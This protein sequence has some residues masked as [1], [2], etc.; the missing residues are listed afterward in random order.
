MQ[1]LLLVL[2]PLI[3]NYSDCKSRNRTILVRVEMG[4]K[5]ICGTYMYCFLCRSIGISVG[6]DMTLLSA[7]YLMSLLADSYQIC[8]DVSVVTVMGQ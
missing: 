2:N 1:G 8:I 3:E 6:I 5:G 7:K 4:A